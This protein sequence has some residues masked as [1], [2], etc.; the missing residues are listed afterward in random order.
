VS[1]I[2]HSFDRTL[3]LFK[4]HVHDPDLWQVP[5]ADLRRYA[6]LPRLPPPPVLDSSDD[7]LP[8]ASHLAMLPGYAAAHPRPRPALDVDRKPSGDQKFR[9]PAD[10]DRKSK[11]KPCTD[12]DEPQQGTK[13]G[14]PHG[15]GNYSSDDIKVL[16]DFVEEEIP[17]GQRGWKAIHQRFSKWA[18]R[19]RRPQRT[20]KS[21][22]TKFKQVR[23][24]T[25]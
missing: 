1:L 14:R 20:V 19:H 2:I 7:D 6:A 18:Q 17:L 12:V 25:P 23:G 10:P 21:L 13:R 4:P 3:N 22:D 15:A 5:S 16:L 11:R 24:F 9:L 8:D